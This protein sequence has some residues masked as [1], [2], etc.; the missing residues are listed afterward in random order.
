MV[1]LRIR[2]L[3]LL[4]C[5]TLTVAP[6]F[7]AGPDTWVPARW[8]GGPL[9]LQRRTRDATAPA[10]PALRETLEQWYEVATLDL[11]RGTP[12]NCLLVTWSAGGEPATER[13]QQQLVA[14]YAREARTRGIAV[15]GLVHSPATPASFL[16]PAIDAGLDGLV[17]EG[18]FPDAERLAAEVRQAL[19]K[20]ASAA[21][22]V[23]SAARAQLGTS[24]EILA[25]ADALAPGLQELGEE[26]EAS[27][28]SEPWIDSNL[29]LLQSVRSRVSS[30]PIW[31]MQTLPA[32]AA[33]ADYLRAIAD[34]AA[35]GGRWALALGDELRHGLRMK[36]GEA[37]AAW[38]R[39]AAFL[40]FQKTH[41]EWSGYPPLAV[42]GFV[43]DS[44]GTDPD[45][46]GANL[47]LAVR[48]RIPLRVIE[49]SQLSTA[50]LDRL[51]A[52]HAID[53]VQPTPPE[54]QI[55][56]EFAQNGGLLVVG[57]TW[58]KVQIPEGQDFLALPAGKGRVVVCREGL[59]PAELAR[60]LVDQLGRDN[61]GVRLF[62]AASVLGH[63]SVG[64]TGSD[65]LVH[66]VNY[67]S[68]P[69]ESVLVRMS[70]DFRRARLYTPD[71]APEELPLD[72]RGGRVEVAVGRLPVYGVLRFE[73]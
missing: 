62:R 33:P 56:A 45:V 4:A 15:L 68:Y 12:I 10:T 47:R 49:R 17:L 57:P 14:A 16:E 7:A 51:R 53:V 25:A 22:V 29:W 50:A 59:D 21:V 26:A 46:S 39:V 35:G 34:A 40:E 66:L 1:L 43:Q 32:Q 72:S 36:D 37:V 6:A 52:V 18:A 41:A 20:R 44:A 54:R 9:E 73:K 64:A 23:V 30:R 60:A 65:A 28:S 67:A 69:A 27:P 2:T 42:S 58:Q 70:G 63:A 71:S 61:L 3:A 8:Q 24:S 31:L 38:R 48:A 55:L 19:R 13:A 5:T 11:L